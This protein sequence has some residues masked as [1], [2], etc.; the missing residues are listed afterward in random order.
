MAYH[1]VPTIQFL[2]GPDKTNEQ[3]RYDRGVKVEAQAP[4]S[5]LYQQHPD[6]KTAAD[7]VIKDTAALK[8]AMD[9]SSAAEA[10][11]AA[12]R[13]A[14]SNAIL[15]WDGSYSVFAKLGEK[16]ATTPND[17]A[18]VGA[19][20]RGKTINP[21]AM[22][23]SVELTYNR[24]LDAIRVRVERA[25][26][27]RML[28]VQLSPDP[29]TPTSWFELDGSGAVHLYPHPAKGTWWARVQSRTAKA[30]S[31]FTVPVSVIVT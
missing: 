31:D 25:P 1:P 9:S 17:A 11:G 21:L 3:T 28:T 4:G 13:T 29:I 8:A 7:E 19:Q 5:P 15:K 18:S 2:V 23:I 26:G 22:P 24:L 14:L 6:L 10:A 20:A 27:M 16:Y 12:A 30:R